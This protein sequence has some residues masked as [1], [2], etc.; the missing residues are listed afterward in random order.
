MINVFQTKGFLSS[1]GISSYSSGTPLTFDTLAAP[2]FIPSVYACSYSSGTFTVNLAGPYLL[3]L[4]AT[5]LSITSSSEGV[6]SFL[7]VNG[8]QSTQQ[9]TYSGNLRGGN[10]SYASI[11][12]TQSFSEGDTFYLS[13]VLT[14][15]PTC[16]VNGAFGPIQSTFFTVTY[17]GFI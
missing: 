14:G 9:R 8:S 5:P 11:L 17:L 10:S 2:T 1:A 15:T 13:L 7:Q 4:V 16:T 3:E 6:Q 12:W